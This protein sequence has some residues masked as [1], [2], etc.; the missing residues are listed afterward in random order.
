MYITNKNKK[1]CSPMTDSKR[2]D[3]W[4]GKSI[5]VSTYFLKLYYSFIIFSLLEGRHVWQPNLDQNVKNYFCM[6]TVLLFRS[7]AGYDAH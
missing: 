4:Y 5:R 7:G 2:K 3:Q 6:S 1:R